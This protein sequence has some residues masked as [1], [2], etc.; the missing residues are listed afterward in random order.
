MWYRTSAMGA[1]TLPNIAEE[2]IEAA[3]SFY[4]PVSLSGDKCNICG[5]KLVNSNYA[6]VEEYNRVIDKYKQ[7][8]SDIGFSE[9]ESEKYL[10][11]FQED[12]K[13]E[14]YC[15][16]CKSQENPYMYQFDFQGMNDWLKSWRDTVNN[17]IMQ[18]K[19]L[20]G[21]YLQNTK[22]SIE[23]KIIRIEKVTSDLFFKRGDDPLVRGEYDYFFNSI[24]IYDNPISKR[25]VDFYLATIRHELGHAFSLDKKHTTTNTIYNKQQSN[26]L[27]DRLML[28]NNIQLKSLE[29]LEKLD[30]NQMRPLVE[31]RIKQVFGS[32]IVMEPGLIELISKI[33]KN[34]LIQSKQNLM[35]NL[36]YSDDLK[37]SSAYYLYFTS[38]T[39]TPTFMMNMK[40]IFS[41]DNLEK[42]RADKFRNISKQSY[43]NY[44][45]DSIRNWNSQSILKYIDSVSSRVSE[46]ISY[47]YNDIFFFMEI[48][49]R[50]RIKKFIRQLQ[51]NLVILVNDYCSK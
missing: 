45:K 6:N 40:V 19:S 13:E 22:F 38:P 31:K 30:I 8:L 33:T 46:H 34:I 44:L 47:A 16:N 5:S 51:N 9:L 28:D 48:D 20:L 50:P 23:D 43:C 17:R 26:D 39:E 1:A 18:D 32:D 14:N 11:G 12:I 10:K 25:E 41:A 42:F 2:I 36:D 27:F 24:Q 21:S 29:E 7:S 37:S 4:K 35:K 15:P 49:D 3:R